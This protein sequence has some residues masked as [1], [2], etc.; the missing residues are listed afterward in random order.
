[1]FFNMTGY[2][3]TAESVAKMDKALRKL[4]KSKQQF[5]IAILKGRQPPSQTLITFEA[6]LNEHGVLTVA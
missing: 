3:L 6:Q 1:M 4:R 5:V 2:I